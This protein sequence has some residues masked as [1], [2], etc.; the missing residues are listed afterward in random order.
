M[1]DI[2]D[3]VINHAHCVCGET[4][5]ARNVDSEYEGS[6]VSGVVGSVRYAFVGFVWY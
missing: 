1:R 3:A 6:G 5:D 2:F 4:N